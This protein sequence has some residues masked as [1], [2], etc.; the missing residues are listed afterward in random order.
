MVIDHGKLDIAIGGL[1]ER[2]KAGD[3][4]KGTAVNEIPHVIQ[5]VAQ[6]NKAEVLTVISSDKGVKNE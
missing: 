4:D 1:L 6:G 3:V 2:F 5:A